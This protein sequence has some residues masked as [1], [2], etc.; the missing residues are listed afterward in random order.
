MLSESEQDRSQRGWRANSG[1]SCSRTSGSHSGNPSP[2][3]GAHGGCHQCTKT[4]TA[5]NYC[6][7]ET[8]KDIFMEKF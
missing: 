2:G 7:T 1:C 3:H 8:G 4:A 6:S 5:A